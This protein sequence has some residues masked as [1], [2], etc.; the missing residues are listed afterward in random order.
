M[1]EILN[2]F[3]KLFENFQYL[4]L[5]QVAMWIIGG[6]LIFL[7]IKKEM[8]PTLLL[9]MGFGAIIVNLPMSSA[10][11]Q[12]LSN[13]VEKKSSPMDSASFFNSAC[14]SHGV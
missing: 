9:P 13:G 14:H 1:T 4:Q 12:V 3:L 6:L 7:A 2:Q 5:N 10:I 11:T 8:E